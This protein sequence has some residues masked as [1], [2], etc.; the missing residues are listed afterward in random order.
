MS[1][2]SICDDATMQS[3]GSRQVIWVKRGS[4]TIASC[5]QETI[6]EHK[7]RL[8]DRKLR[9]Q[10]GQQ[11]RTIRKRQRQIVKSSTQAPTKQIERLN[12]G[13]RPE[14][15]QFASSEPATFYGDC[16]LDCGLRRKAYNG[17]EHFGEIT[18][19][20]YK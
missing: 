9:S 10:E 13:E 4:Y 7:T 11:V 6:M 8:R 16:Q 3:D 18:A 14:S 2:R 19:S 1:P 12:P 17:G 5:D 15:A 20:L